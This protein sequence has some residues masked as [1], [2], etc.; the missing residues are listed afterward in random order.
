MWQFVRRAAI[1]ALTV[2]L[3]APSVSA[4]PSPVQRLAMTGGPVPDFVGASF[5]SFHLAPVATDGAVYYAGRWLGNDGIIRRAGA[6]SSMM[7]SQFT[8][9]PGLQSQ[10]NGF[11]SL[12]ASG[13][14]F[15]FLASLRSAAGETTTGA[16]ASLTEGL[17]L[18]AEAQPP[19]GGSQFFQQVGAPSIDGNTISVWG[20]TPTSGVSPVGVFQTAGALGEAGRVVRL[21]QLAPSG[22][23]AFTSLG[24][25][26]VSG[27]DDTLFWGATPN[28]QGLY[29]A[30]GV[31]VAD[32]LVDN[33]TP[34]TG[35]VSPV[36]NIR[37]NFSWDGVF[38]A[39]IGEGT[40]GVPGVYL[41]STD[42]ATRIASLFDGIPEGFGAF[43]DFQDVAVSGER[44]VFTA[45][46]TQGQQG[47]YAWLEGDLVRLVDRNTTLEDGKSI[48]MIRIGR[49][50]IFE[51]TVAF[52]ADFTD[53]SSGVYTFALAPIPA[54]GAL[55]VLAA[56]ALA[57]RRRA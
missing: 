9:V 29:I 15:A 42:G 27:G 52:I 28:R 47:L 6:T 44:V 30:F 35:D 8:F 5:T 22:G 34:I 25:T 3:A 19:E 16:F 14:Q 17:T 24:A 48:A 37:Q 46:G 20:L 41:A 1:T 54:P 32:V 39:F 10:F 57:R 49:E 36:T 31:A 51:D 33:A 53:G 55:T 26:P 56:L 38:A 45:T 43:F 7:I 11:E 23:Q 40:F 2:G 13:G 50:A 21:G 18:L 12:S 4:M